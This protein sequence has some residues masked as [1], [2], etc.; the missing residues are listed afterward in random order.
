[1][2]FGR[3][4]RAVTV[5]LAFAGC[6]KS[7]PSATSSTTPPAVEAAPPAATA[8]RGG[9]VD[10]TAPSGA[11]VILEPQTPGEFAAPDQAVMDQVSLAFTPEMLF[12]RTGHPVE[13]RNNDD[14][15]HNVHVGN[16]DTKEPAFNVAIPTGEA[17][18]FTFSKDGFY[19][20]ACDI[21]PA[22]SAEILSVSTPF[23]TMARADG[24]FSFD[25][26]PVGAYVAR[27]FAA[28]IKKERAVEIVAGPNTLAIDGRSED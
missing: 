18:R 19:H 13:F 26:V 17:Y 20:V 21:H 1:M 15:L 11:I 6:S 25:D 23:V 5:L 7:T 28:G 14:T 10:G 3:L 12:V 24:T 16:A 8:N 9:H 22:M 2:R 4:T 27:S